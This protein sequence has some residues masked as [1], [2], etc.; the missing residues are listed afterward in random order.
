[1]NAA[2]ELHEG[3]RSGIGGRRER[4]RSTLVIIEVAFSIVLLVAFGLLTR[5]LWRIQAV[6]PGFRPDHVLTLRTSL[7]MPRYENVDVRAAF[8]RRVLEQTRRI[9]GVIAAGYTSFLP[10]VAGGIWPVEIQ[11][12]PEDLANRRTASLRFVTPGFFSAMGIPLFAGRDVRETDAEHAPY[13]ALISRSFVKRY[14]PGEDPLGRHIDIGNHDRRIIG[15]VGDIRNRGLERSSEPQVYVSWLQPDDVSTWNAPKDLAIRT[16]GDPTSLISSLRAIIRETD[17]TQP[18]SDVQTLTDIVEDQTA[19]RRVQLTVLGAFGAV[20]LLLAAVG[21]HGLLAFAVSSRT[22]EIGVRIALGAQ[23]SD[24]FN[25]TLGEGAKLA[26]IGMLVG[27]ALAYGA[28]RLLQS[29]LA[30]IKPSDLSTFATAVLV[31]V[32]MTFAGSLMPA[33][34]AVRVDPT[35]AM[36]AE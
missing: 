14:W 11:G 20:A 9:P 5:A 24:I 32:A 36:R 18:I 21:I 8:Y 2:S 6:N 12:H 13:V 22:Q 25:M 33:I 1:V 3:G 15:V 30:D 26:G 34:R 23:R 10:M 29:L 4:L 27:I 35:V 31:T 28:G 16:A 19:F 17:P 7:P